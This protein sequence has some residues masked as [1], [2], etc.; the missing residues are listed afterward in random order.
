MAVP[1]TELPRSAAADR[2]VA[3]AT[4]GRTVRPAVRAV[5]AKLALVAATL[6]LILGVAEVATRLFASVTPP[7]LRNDPAVGTTFLPGFTGTIYVPE[8]RRD[9]VLRFNRDGLRGP[10][11][12]YEKPAGVRRVAVVGDSMIAAIATDEDET[13]VRRLEQ[14]LNESEPNAR[15]EV[16]NFG[17]SG[18]STGQELALYRERVRRYKPD[19]VI[20]AFCVWN[21]LADNCRRLTSSRARI[22]FDLDDGGELARLPTSAGR[23]R[24]TAWLNQYSR[25]YVWQKYTTQRAIN[26]V[27]RR[28]TELAAL[29]GLDL[30]LG[31][32]SGQGIFL[33]EPSGDVAHAWRITEKLIETMHREVRADGAEFL[34]AVLPGG[35]QVCDDSW[36]E[37]I[38]TAAGT[39]DQHYPD[40]R[41]TELCGRLGAPIV[42]MT[43]R[44]RDAAPH[45]S[46]EQEDEWLH[47]EGLGHFN[48][49]G[50]ELAA[51]ALRDALAG[52]T[53]QLAE[54]KAD[55]PRR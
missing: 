53:S 37:V 44:F 48:D 17:I 41:L 4:P 12:P 9:V 54:Q 14:L 32:A 22:Y 29:G 26:T 20:C 33:T 42:V 45:H 5:L 28:A 23:A 30:G 36:Q 52:P 49:R 13:L 15:W 46:I 25:F 6:V 40:R 27:R 24:L 35:L 50:N 16:L 7:L 21:D 34:L 2:A 47:Y 18:S 38:A 31:G 55:A 43:D 8:C 19:V 3:G 10:D 11:V 39:M 1:Q 51:E